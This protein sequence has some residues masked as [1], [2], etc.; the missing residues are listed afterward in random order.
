ME[1]E[2]LRHSHVG[3]EKL[4]H[5]LSSTYYWPTLKADCAAYAGR[6]FECQVAAGRSTGSWAGKL[7]PLPPGPR[8]VWACDLIEQIGSP[9]GTCKGHI[10]TLVDCYSKFCLLHH[11]PDKAST[12]VAS[13]L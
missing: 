12:T 11:L 5:I 4:Y 13:A 7:L 10:L 3:G 8:V 1:E 9:G 6:C 2:H